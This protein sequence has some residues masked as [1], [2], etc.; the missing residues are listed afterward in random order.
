[1][2]KVTYSPRLPYFF[3][4]GCLVEPVGVLF[5][6]LGWQRVKEEGGISVYRQLPEKGDH[7][8][9]D[10]ATT[11]T[12]DAANVEKVSLALRDSAPSKYACVKC[13]GEVRASPERIFELLTDDTRYVRTPAWDRQHNPSMNK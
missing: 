3:L 13:H 5:V 9:P 10:S 7:A 1:M 8:S 4:H 12:T 6:P 11:G 2:L